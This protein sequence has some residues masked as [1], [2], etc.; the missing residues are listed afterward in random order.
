[1]TSMK[2]CIRPTGCWLRPGRFLT[3]FQPIGDRSGLGAL[4]LSA[5]TMDP[6]RE[7]R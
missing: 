2:R 1:M 6:K 5:A 7:I 3:E 4:H